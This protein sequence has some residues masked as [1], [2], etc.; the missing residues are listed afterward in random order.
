MK[1][2][3]APFLGDAHCGLFGITE[4]YEEA[5]LSLDQHF[6][7]QREATFFFR[8]KGDC[9]APL[10]TP[11]DILIVDRSRTPRSGQVVVATLNGERVCKRLRQQG[12]RVCLITD[13]PKHPP[14]W[15]DGEHDDFS[16][17][18]VVVALARHLDRA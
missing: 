1:P 2:E 8:A 4:D 16:I 12:A 14:R 11:G 6:V 18:G 5:Y 7:Q 9:M 15:I 10:I 13:N 3:R 17:F